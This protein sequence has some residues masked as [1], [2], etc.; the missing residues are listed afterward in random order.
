[1]NKNE[2]D[3]IV[4]AYSTGTMSTHWD[5]CYLTHQ[6]CALHLLA[7]ELKYAMFAIS[8]VVKDGSVID[9]WEGKDNTARERIAFLSMRYSVSPMDAMRQK[10][11]QEMRDRHD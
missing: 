9:Y 5:K 6:R 1:M 7:D 2:V 3:E 11:E 8:Q 4:R 10:F